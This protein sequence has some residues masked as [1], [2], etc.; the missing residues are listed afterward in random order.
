MF[1]GSASDANI[2]PK[3]QAAID[4]TAETGRVLV[5]GNATYTAL[6]TINIPERGHIQGQKKT[7]YDDGFGS[8]PKASRINFNPTSSKVLFNFNGTSHSGFRLHTS[9]EGVSMFGNANALNALDLNGIIYSRFANLAIDGFTYGITCDATINN[10]FENILIDNCITAC[11]LYEGNLETTDVWDQVTFFG[12][13]SGVTFA[14]SSLS[15]RFVHCLFEQIGRFGLNMVAECQNIML[16]HCYAEDVVF[17]GGSGDSFIRAGASGTP[18][19]T[20]NLTVIGGTYNGRNAGNAGSFIN[21]NLVSGIQVVGATV[22]RFEQ[23]ITASANTADNSIVVHGVQGISWDNGFYVGPADKIQG[24]FPQSTLGSAS[25]GHTNQV[26]HS[27]AEKFLPTANNASDIGTDVLRMGNAYIRTLFVGSNG[28]T[29]TY[30]SGANTPEGAITATVGSVFTR[31]N[32][33]ANTTLYVKE[34]GTGNTGW[35]A[36]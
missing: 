25:Y 33:G 20:N 26:R 32:G 19:V 3:F 36:I 12:T 30:S 4:F 17:D 7:Q 31:T 2:S 22:S 35:A 5:L 1:G 16:D 6:D 21:S 14:G 29:A 11:V 13:T 24:T 23:V 18:V 10:R 9:I 27:I 28:N 8:D 34:S 15:I